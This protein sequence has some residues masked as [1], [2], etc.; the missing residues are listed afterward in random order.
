MRSYDGFSFMLRCFRPLEKHISIH[1]HGQLGLVIFH[2]TAA[3]HEQVVVIMVV[4]GRIVVEGHDFGGMG[5]M[6]RGL[7]SSKKVGF[8]SIPPAMR[9]WA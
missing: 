6:E 3:A 4:A 9:L 8:R 5:F 7:A 1:P 2:Q